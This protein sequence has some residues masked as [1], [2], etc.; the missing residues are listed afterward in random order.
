M[1]QLGSSTSNPCRKRLRRCLEGDNGGIYLCDLLHTL[2][3]PCS[4]NPYISSL[5][6]VTITTS[7]TTPKAHIILYNG[8]QVKPC[9]NDYEYYLLYVL[10]SLVISCF[11]TTIR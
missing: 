8:G 3:K 2:V 10:S 6:S 9:T 11:V 4:A 1:L 7:S 5:I